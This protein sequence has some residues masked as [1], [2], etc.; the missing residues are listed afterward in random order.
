MKVKRATEHL[1][2]RGLVSTKL[3]GKNKPYR[4]TR[5]A[6]EMLTPIAGESTRYRLVP[7]QD[8]VLYS[9]TMIILLATIGSSQTHILSPFPVLFMGWASCIFIGVS[10]CRFIEMVKK[11]F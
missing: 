4:L 9:A 10:L 11:V 7:R 1:Q 6:V 8:A 3:F 2:A 5:Y